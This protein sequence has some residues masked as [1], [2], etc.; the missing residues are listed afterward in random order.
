M[1]VNEQEVELSFGKI[2]FVDN[3]LIESGAWES[4]HS[5][6]TTVWFKELAAVRKK[7]EAL[8]NR[9]FRTCVCIYYPDG[10]SGVAYHFDPLD[11]GDI[12]VIPSLSLGEE[13]DF[14]LREQS[15]QEEFCINLKE[16]S[17]IVMGEGCQERYEHSLPENP[18]YKH[19]RINITFRQFGY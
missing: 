15:T 14:C 11:F 3:D 5:T 7:V 16:G 18:K 13:C 12:I 6:N 1:Y 9:V 17:L 19:P 10:N 8:T 2:M 4:R